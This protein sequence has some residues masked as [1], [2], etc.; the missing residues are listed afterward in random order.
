MSLAADLWQ[1]SLTVY[2]RPGVAK[3]CLYLQD[4]WD[5][6]INIILWLLWLEQQDVQVNAEAIAIAETAT[7]AWRT[8]LVKPLRQLRRQLAS[9]FAVAEELIGTIYRQLK[10]AELQ[11][12]QV[13][14]EL[15]ADL[16]IGV[17]F[18]ALPQGTNLAIYLN[19]LQVPAIDQQ[20]LLD[21]LKVC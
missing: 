17:Q 18:R 3:Q 11:A 6:N 14:Q 21:L 7:A 13:E 2:A 19:R 10:T 9:E 8:T 20:R 15:L 16:H 12:E 5:A 4:E 1:F